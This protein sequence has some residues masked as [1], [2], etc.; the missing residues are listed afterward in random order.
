MSEALRKEFEYYLAHQDEFVAR[1]DGRVIALKDGIMLGD[2]DTP[3]DAMLALQDTHQL[4]TYLI[5]RVSQGEKDTVVRIY[6]PRDVSIVPR[7]PQRLQC[8]EQ[9]IEDDIPLWPTLTFPSVAPFG[10][11]TLTTLSL[12]RTSSPL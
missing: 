2:F 11:G 4:G 8:I 9:C 3:S 10:L 5:Q 6:S 7:V 1:Y 12:E